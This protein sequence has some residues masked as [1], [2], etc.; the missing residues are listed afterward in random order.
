VGGAGPAE[1]AASVFL[2]PDAGEDTKGEA[3]EMIVTMF[4]PGNEVDIVTRAA[5]DLRIDLT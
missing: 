2:D 5:D 4:E 3:V 1:F